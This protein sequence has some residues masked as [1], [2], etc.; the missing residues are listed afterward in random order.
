MDILDQL[1]WWWKKRTSD[2]AD[3]LIHLNVYHNVAVW[4]CRTISADSVHT[5]TC[6]ISNGVNW[7]NTRAV[8][9]CIWRWRCIRC[10]LISWLKNNKISSRTNNNDKR[11]LLGMIELIFITYS[12]INYNL[13]SHCRRSFGFSVLRLN[14]VKLM[15]SRQLKKTRHRL[16]LI[17]SYG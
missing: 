10:T 6:A 4:W 13:L 7:T 14:S 11:G 17:A 1:F 2:D 3:H 5:I 12:S 8:L 9:R 15:S 16:F